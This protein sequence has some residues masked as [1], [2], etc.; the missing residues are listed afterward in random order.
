R[1]ETKVSNGVATI[2]IYSASPSDCG[3]YSCVVSSDLGQA[4]T[5]A[6]LRIFE[7]F[8][9]TPS[10]PT[11]TRRIQDKYDYRADELTLECKVQGQPRP[12]ITWKKDDKSLPARGR[13]QQCESIDGTCR[14][15]ISGPEPQDSGVYTCHAEN[16]VWNEQISDVV[17]FEG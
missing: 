5:T 17:T 7:K 4:T 15:V 11:F 14:L 12:T 3:R 6:T 13:Y 10:P 16:A 2:E 8:E 9:P 1:C